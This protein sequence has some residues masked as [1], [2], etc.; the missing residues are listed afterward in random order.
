MTNI[1]RS[2][3]DAVWPW[4]RQPEEV[5]RRRAAVARR[6]GAVQAAVGLLAASLLALWK[7]VLGTVVAAVALVVLTLALASPLAGFA[8]LERLIE[9][10][11]HLVGLAVTWLLMPLIFVLVFL[12]VGLVLRR[13]RLR[14]TG[15]P[16]PALPTYWQRPGGE[17]AAGGGWQ[18]GG[19]ASYRRQF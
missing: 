11:A 9:R 5:P 17:P 12:P 7:P 10:F 16:D 1:P 8:R 6:R 18:R 14:F 13:G 19:L 3:Y 2:P 15:N 4:R